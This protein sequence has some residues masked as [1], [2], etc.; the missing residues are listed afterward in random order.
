VTPYDSGILHA[1]RGDHAK[2]RWRRSR[3]RNAGEHRPQI[4]DY[5][6][7]KGRRGKP[8]FSACPSPQTTTDYSLENAIAIEKRAFDGISSV[9][10]AI[11]GQTVE[12]KSVISTHCAAL[13]EPTRPLTFGRS[14]VYLGVNIEGSP[15]YGMNQEP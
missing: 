6:I 13:K 5:H 3:R 15:R 9:Y 7:F 10:H 2:V 4:C 8:Q 11:D 1:Y 12:I 14:N